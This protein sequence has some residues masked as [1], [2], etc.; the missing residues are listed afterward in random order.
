MGALSLLS[1]ARV[2]VT[3]GA[4]NVGSHIVDAVIAA[5]AREAIALDALVRGVP[6]NLD[7]ALATGK[8]RLVGLSGPT[9]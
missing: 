1:G 2:V 3:G 4:G 7:A 9:P 8:A 5:G 6:E